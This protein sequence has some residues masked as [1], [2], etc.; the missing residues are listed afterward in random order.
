MTSSGSQQAVPLNPLML[1][2]AR[3]TSGK[4]I[5]QA[6]KR[7]RKLA[8]DIEDWESATVSRIPTVKQ[9]RTLASFYG[10][11]FLEFLR[12]SP[13]TLFQPKSI[14]DFRSARDQTSPEQSHII[15]HV[16]AWAEIQRENAL[17]LYLLCGDEPPE[18]PES[19]YAD[20]SSDPE[21]KAEQTRVE[22]AFSIED[23]I[24]LAASDKSLFP[25]IVR[26][27]IE[28][29]GVLTLRSTRL[30]KARKFGV[31]ISEFPLPTIVFAN[32]SPAHQVFTLAHEFGH[33]LLK[34]SGI[35][36]PRRRTGYEPSVALIEQWCNRYAGAFLIP[37][38]ALEQQF[39][40]PPNM[41]PDI[42]NSTLGD[43]AALFRISEHAMLVRLTELGYVD[44]EYYW[45]V[46][47]PEYD[48]QEKNFKSFGRPKYFGSRYRNELGDHY[49]GLV[50][51]AWS[52]G[53]ITN[54]NAA[55]F[56]GIKRLSHLS[57]I[58]NEYYK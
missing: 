22:I 49:T 21:Q 8:E 7:V 9:A 4:S 12:E 41:L 18:F 23:Q 26:S 24:G 45:N 55:E 58:R 42:S 13:P 43:L 40:K 3:E 30:R 36:G 50:L 44:L 47:R 52:N 19:L 6:A 29:V 33:V 37:R 5:D 35:V 14:P 51:S 10:R 54:H 11:S 48:D 2:W 27:K 17:D 28:S 34:K 1:K 56:M 32:T 39:P 38:T 57:D 15:E 25:Q 46:K 16:H 20:T 31:C 53:K